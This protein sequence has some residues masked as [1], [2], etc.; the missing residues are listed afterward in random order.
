MHYEGFKPDGI[1]VGKSLAPGLLLP[2]NRKESFSFEINDKL[3][4]L[5]DAFKPL[6]TQYLL[7]DLS[8][9]HI[10][11]TAALDPGIDYSRDVLNL[12]AIIDAVFAHFWK[13]D[14][15]A[16][17]WGAGLVRYI[18]S[19]IYLSS[20]RS[21]KSA[22]VGTEVYVAG[23]YRLVFSLS[24]LTRFIDGITTTFCPTKAGNGGRLANDLKRRDELR[25]SLRERFLEVA[26]PAAAATGTAAP[27]SAAGGGVGPSTSPRDDDG[28]SGGGRGAKK[29]RRRR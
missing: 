26:A 5:R 16:R 8:G 19:D 21:K 1:I 17:I 23:F 6:L 4:T 29:G 28:D 22:Y 10:Y 25:A 3:S 12:S 13:P 9:C 11:D 7:E 18:P 27:R 24:T 20:P 14:E 15:L 2:V